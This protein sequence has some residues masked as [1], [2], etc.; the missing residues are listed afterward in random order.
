MNTQLEPLINALAQ[1]KS[2]IKKVII[3]HDFVID[4]S[5]IAIFTQQHVLLEGAPGIAKT[6]LVKTLAHVLGCDFSRIQFTPDLMPS[7]IIGTSV[8]NLQKN[9]FTIMQ[10][11]IFTTFL[12]ADEINRSP[13]KTQSA[14]LQAMA[15][16]H[17]TIDRTT[18]A[19]SPLFTVF[20]TQNPIES[21][22]TYPLPEAQKD[23]FIFKLTM[24]YPNREEEIQLA[25][26]TLGHTSP[27]KVLE[28]GQIQAVI[29][30]ELI[31]QFQTALSHVQI[32]PELLYYG[33][34]L[35]RASREHPAV[36]SGGGPRATQSLLLA[37]RAHAALQG[38]DYVTPDDF[39]S[40]FVAVLKHRLLLK[41]EFEM[42]GTDHHI[43]LSQLLEKVEVPR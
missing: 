8:Y 37:S 11:P 15:E 31:Q 41:P 36:L 42:E 16:R 35:V 43:V 33:V 32:R 20:A 28:S 7:D 29:T 30:P 4:Q 21:E 27:E 38:R 40:M 26:K 1:A 3:G 22:G 5:L 23:R 24:D 12:I 10:G 9:D 13:A 18:F 17:V 34:D 14:L 2:E 6:L 39:R 19:L 25:E